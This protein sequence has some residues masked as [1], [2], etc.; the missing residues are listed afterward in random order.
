MSGGG[1]DD[2]RVRISVIIPTIGRDTLDAAVA[3][4]DG[5][6]EVV[7]QPNSDGDRG[8]QA[9]TEAIRRATGTHLAFLDDDDV[10]LPGAL[11]TMAAHACDRPVIFR[12]DDPL[13]GILWRDPDLRYANVGTPMILVPND[14]ARLGQWAPHENGRGGD[15]TFITGCVEKMGPPVWRE[16]IIARVRPHERRTISI[17]T[18]WVDHLELWPDYQ[19]AVQCRGAWDELIVVDN[20]SQPPLPFAT[21]RLDTNAGF[22]GGS[23]AGLDAAV[24]DAV[25]FL[26]NDIAVTRF[27]W[28]DQIRSAL[29]PGV[30]IGAK[31]RT[32]PHASVD[33]T[34]MPYL[35]GW[36]I[37]GLRDDLLE[38]GGFDDTFDEP[39]YYSDNDLCLRAR[40]AG[41][42]LREVRVGLVHKANVTAGHGEDVAR[43]SLANRER[44]AERVR[45]L[46]QVAA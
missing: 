38:L 11:E 42:R 19:A 4:C 33:G 36:C 24:G 46:T 5:A 30:L 17:V 28:L 23:N 37:A 27:D 21:I 45:S 34:P 32:D 18:P 31:L 6:Y 3:S 15:F 26:N 14:P 25:L 8:Y 13:H 35:D 41:M 16:E 1:M 29:E 40:A 12:M 9:R 2:P 43:A 10:Y 7:V 20:G 39:A 22:V 44:Y